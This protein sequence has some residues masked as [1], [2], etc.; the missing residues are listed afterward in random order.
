MARMS[1]GTQ[2]SIFPSVYLHIHMHTQC[3]ITG[4]DE[5]TA[6]KIVK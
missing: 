3:Y 1:L 6:W 5:D 2:L 4:R